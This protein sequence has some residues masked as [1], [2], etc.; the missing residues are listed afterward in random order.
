MASATAGYCPPTRCANRPNRLRD[1]DAVVTNILAC[2]TARPYPPQATGPRQVAMWLEPT[3]ARRV[4]TAP[5]GRWRLRRPAR[6]W[7]RRLA[8]AIPDAFTT[9][10]SPGSPSPRRCHCRIT[11]LRPFALR[12]VGGR[13]HPGDVQDAIKC[14]A[15]H[16]RAC[17]KCR[18]GPV[19]DPWL[20]DWLA[21]RL[22]QPRPD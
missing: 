2:P 21:Q 4:E 19:S 9:L 18:C 5:C 10:R 14:A 16:G 1:V 20:F 22:R 15:L 12:S 8:S 3:D 17:G 7:P 11:R 6:G 13:G